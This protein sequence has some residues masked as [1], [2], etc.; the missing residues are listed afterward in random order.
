MIES[1][2]IT[3]IKESFDKKKI[4]LCKSAT[5]YTKWGFVKGK[6][7]KDEI[8]KHT[9]MRE[10]KEETGITIDYKHLRDIYLATYDDKN[11]GIYLVYM[12]D[13]VDIEKYFKKEKLKSKFMDMENSEVGFFDIDELPPIK[14]KQKEIIR[15]IR[16]AI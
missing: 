7:K 11:I 2:G 14:E 9:A 4:L 13:V 8:P 16:S 6:A 5:S 1:F 3:I 12:D 15:Q 10:F